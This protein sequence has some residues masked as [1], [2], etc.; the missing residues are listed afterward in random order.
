MQG[1]LSYHNMLRLIKSVIRRYAQANKLWRISY[2]LF[3]LCQ[4]FS[5]QIAWTMTKSKKEGVLIMCKLSL[6]IIKQFFNGESRHTA[7]R[8]NR[9]WPHEWY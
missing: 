9:L 6:Y 7:R 5:S 3:S 1:L 8:P 2:A 4:L